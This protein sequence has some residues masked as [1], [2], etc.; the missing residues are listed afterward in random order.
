MMLD[1]AERKVSFASLVIAVSV[2]SAVSHLCTSAM[3]LQIGALIDGLGL[4]ASAAGLVGF[5]QV[6]ALAG[7][8]ILFSA[9][10]H[11]FRPLHS[12]IV[13]MLL[14]MV[15]NI[16]LFAVGPNL[17]LLCLLGASSGL[18]YGLILS[19]AVSVAAAYVRPD[20][21]YALGN[22]GSLL[23][24]VALL[25]LLPMA[26]TFFGERGIF[27]GVAILLVVSIPLVSGFRLSRAA[28][29]PTGVS[30][31][32]LSERLPLVMIWALFSFGTGAIWTFTERIGHG[33]GLSDQLIGLILSI[34]VFLGLT[35]TGL[36]ALSNGRMSR[37]TSIAIGLLG[38]GASCLLLAAA[39]N[40]VI[41][42]MAA[43]LYWVFTMYL[44]V[45]LLGTAA[46]LDPTGRLGT[47]CT[48]CERLAFAIS[49]PVG[50]LFVDFGSF[51][52][53]GL[54]T[55]ITCAVI[56][57]LCLPALAR[58]LRRSSEAASNVAAEI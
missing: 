18:G 7:S 45:V 13:G 47:L 49:A 56:A 23:L 31:N 33:L 55:G 27:L 38:G 12:C 24:V 48:G 5:F 29:L 32:G 54:L 17:A 51:L 44:Y 53:I 35:G 36:A 16:G 9:V 8:M 58:A 19:A 43:G 4:S 37:V 26:N 41:Y 30:L 6:G 34:S 57:P 3:P 22:S 25:A 20:R 39:S 14:A 28:R 2:G 46:A 1:V 11:L 42:A 10:A 21:L 52:W 50:G 15:S 40:V